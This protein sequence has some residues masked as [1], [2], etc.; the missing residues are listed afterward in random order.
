MTIGAAIIQFLEI[1]LLI[2]AILA[3]GR[4]FFLVGDVQ[5]TVVGIESTKTEINATL[6]RVEAVADAT[7]RLMREEL[8]PTLQV[9][10]ETIAHVEVTTRA[11]AET[12]QIARKLAGHLEDAQKFFSVSGPIAQTI[13]KK[14]SGMAG[15]LL[16]GLSV[17][18]KSVV[19]KRK[20]PDSADG[21]LLLP[22]ADENVAIPGTG[23]TNPVL[24]AE[25]RVPAGSRP[26]RKK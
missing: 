12:T 15:G 23:T 2:V 3:V 8:T 18:I 26:G 25:S 6:K 5:K 7:E 10:R 1:V 20:N 17:G 21:R 9:A 14:A 22:P 24:H 13:L 19:G 16:S 4:I 11:L